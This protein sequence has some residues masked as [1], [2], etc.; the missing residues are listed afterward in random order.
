MR[1]TKT[2]RRGERGFTIIEMLI[3][4]AIMMVVTGATFQLMDPAQGLFASQPELSDMNQRLRVGVE[5]MHKDLLMAGAGTFN[6]SKAGSLNYYFAA[7]LPFR[8]GPTAPDIM[9]KHYTDRMSL[10]YVPATPTQTT[11]KT[12]MS[13]TTSNVVANVEAGCPASDATNACGFKVGTMALIFDD[14]GAYDVFRVSTVTSAAGPPATV[15]LA[16]ASPFTT[17]SKKYAAGAYISEVVALTYWLKT[18]TTNEVYQLMKYDGYLTDSPVVE[19]VVGL[20]FTY[21]GEPGPP[22]LRKALS[23]PKGPWTNYGPKPPALGVNNTDDTWGNGE[24][25]MFQVTSNKTVT[26]TEMAT[27][28]GSVTG[29]LVELTKAQLEDGPWCAD[30]SAAFRY[31][32]DLMRVRTVRVSI[33]VQASSKSMRGPTGTLFTRGGTSKSSQRYL[34]DQEVNFEVSPR[35]MNLTR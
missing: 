35:N 29:R 11:L 28:L 9:Q 21:F 23:D 15:T 6:G 5:A 16:H 32:A 34:P 25:C 18:D 27:A 14:T 30:G 17:F 12:T 7:V 22:V 13:L 31:D 2:I 20:S 1:S 10:I 33:R 24:N 19:N 26:R 4:T 8:R 3:A